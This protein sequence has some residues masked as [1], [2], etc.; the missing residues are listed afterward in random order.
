MDTEKYVTL[1]YGSC[2]L[3]TDE[4]GSVLFCN[5]YQPTSCTNSTRLPP[6]LILPSGREITLCSQLELY[7]V[8]QIL[9]GKGWD[10]PGVAC[11][12]PVA[13]TRSWRRCQPSDSRVI[14]QRLAGY[15]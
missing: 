9:P 10:R 12:R 7:L 15:A 4:V 6:L 3:L 2:P 13:N 8:E 14:T 5:H 11:L 1:V